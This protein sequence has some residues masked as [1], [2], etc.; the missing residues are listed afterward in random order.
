MYVS[1]HGSKFTATCPFALAEDTD[2]RF[3]PFFV[4]DTVSAIPRIEIVQQLTNKIRVVSLLAILF[5]LDIAGIN[6]VGSVD[7]VC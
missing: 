5:R 3:I 6:I 4:N 2:I 1:R 7:I